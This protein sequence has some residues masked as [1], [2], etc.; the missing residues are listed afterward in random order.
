MKIEC[1][2]IRHVM[3]IGRIGYIMC[4]EEDSRGYAKESY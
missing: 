2:S 4:V 1:L 3:S